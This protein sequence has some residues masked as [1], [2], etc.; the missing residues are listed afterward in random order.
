M[1]KQICASDANR[2]IN[3]EGNKEDVKLGKQAKPTLFVLGALYPDS[4]IKSKPKKSNKWM[5]KMESGA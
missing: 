3:A 2:K 4:G 1:S 5:V